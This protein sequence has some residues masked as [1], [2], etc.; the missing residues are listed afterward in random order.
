MTKIKLA[1][2]GCLGRMGQQ[3]IKSSKKDRAFKIVSL[4]ENR[5]SRRS[6]RSQIEESLDP[7][8]SATTIEAASA[9]GITSKHRAWNPTLLALPYEFFALAHEPGRISEPAHALLENLINRLPPNDRARLWTYSYQLITATTTLGIARVIRACLP[10]RRDS[11]NRILPT[12]GDEI[13]SNGLPPRPLMANINHGHQI[14]A[15]PCC[16]PSEAHHY[17]YPGSPPTPLITMSPSARPVAS[18]TDRTPEGAVG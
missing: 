9:F 18:T 14:T 10:I 15:L 5:K 8:C 1:I 12:P 16:F 7:W 2:T 17:D 13:P 6:R 11:S 3:L 4:T